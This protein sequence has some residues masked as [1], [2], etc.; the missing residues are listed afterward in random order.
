MWY[1]SAIAGRALAGHWLKRKLLKASETTGFISLG[2]MLTTLIRLL[3][4]M[5]YESRLASVSAI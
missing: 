4:S 2:G 3:S 1:F 5:P